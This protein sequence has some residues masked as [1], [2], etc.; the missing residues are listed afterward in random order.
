MLHKNI[1]GLT[2]IVI[3]NDAKQKK[4][5]RVII[6]PGEQCIGRQYTRRK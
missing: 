4:K 5:L 1:I 6:N 3:L 2:F